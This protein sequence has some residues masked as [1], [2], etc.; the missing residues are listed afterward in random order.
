MAK[1]MTKRPA[2]S[3]RKSKPK[4]AAAAPKPSRRER[5]PTSATSGRTAGPLQ[6]FCRT[7]PGATEDVKWGAD[8][9][10]SVG[11]K[12][13]AAFDLETPTNFGF[14]C[15]P[16]EQLR[17]IQMPGIIPAPYAAKHGW[18]FVH[19]KRALSITEAKRRLRDSYGLVLERLPNRA[20]AEILAKVPPA[21]ARAK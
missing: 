18:V 12:M 10:F 2:A 8:L 6:A 9:V 5:A 19:E 20:R 1:T 17:L 21:R 15:T 7:L 11:G 16:E 4:S 14:K 3:P 13:F